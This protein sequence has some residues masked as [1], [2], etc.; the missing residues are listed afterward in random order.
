MH[1][2]SC[3]VAVCV[4]ILQETQGGRKQLAGNSIVRRRA[5]GGG[6]KQEEVREFH[7]GFLDVLNGPV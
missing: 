5:E 2:L 3:F 7:K 6:Q 1:S 4:Y